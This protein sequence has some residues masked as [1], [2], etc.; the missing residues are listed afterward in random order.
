MIRL[1]G[2]IIAL[3]LTG[4]A[5]SPDSGEPFKVRKEVK[6]F[7]D[8]LMIDTDADIKQLLKPYGNPDSIRVETIPNKHNPAAKD[9][10]YM[11]HY[12]DGQ[13]V[14]YAVPHMGRNYILQA[15]LT[16]KF[17]P[18]PLSRHIGKSGKEVIEY[19]GNP[20]QTTGNDFIY[21]CSM[22]AEQF[23]QLHMRKNRVAKLEI[24]GWVD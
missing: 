10:V 22:E 11:A 5:M 4:C 15:M 21:H 18:G 7:C 20:D 3:L 8:L 17:W 24:K 1:R 19:F 23:I 9:K 2:F 6:E 12:T 13:I 14:I 16:E